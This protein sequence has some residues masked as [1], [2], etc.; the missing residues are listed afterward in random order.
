MSLRV[1]AAALAI[2]LIA[3]LSLGGCAV[4]V[5][6]EDGPGDEPPVGQRVMVQSTAAAAV[7]KTPTP[8]APQ[9]EPPAP[10][11]LDAVASSNTWTLA[12]LSAGT[13]SGGVLTS[14]PTCDAMTGAISQQGAT[15]ELTI[16]L[17]L[18]KGKGCTVALSGSLGLLRLATSTIPRTGTPYFCEQ[19]GDAL[20]WVNVGD[21]GGWGEYAY[22][23]VKTPPNALAFSS[24]TPSIGL[25]VR[26]RG[27]S[28]AHLGEISAV[29]HCDERL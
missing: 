29:I 16:N 12:P 15:A 22:G 7:A 17:S 28:A 3:L 11:P 20:M 18:Y 24:L 21:G 13:L 14:S 4:T 6:Y 26:L 5:G 8:P 25:R 23:A 27:D 1:V 9:P 2:T 10:K 19:R